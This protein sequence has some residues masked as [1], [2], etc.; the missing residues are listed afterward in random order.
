MGNDA[1]LKV[2][3]VSGVLLSLLLSGRLAA[4]LLRCC[5]G[6][7]IPLRR[8]LFGA[9]LQLSLPLFLILLLFGNLPLT[10]LEI[11]VRFPHVN[12]PCA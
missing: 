8:G 10:L 12:T 4:C 1:T 11:E 6:R 2:A 3:E 5:S 7:L 9:S